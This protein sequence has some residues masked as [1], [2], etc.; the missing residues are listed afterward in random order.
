ML[1]SKAT[2]HIDIADDVGQILNFG[3]IHDKTE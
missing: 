1:P 3:L 2:A